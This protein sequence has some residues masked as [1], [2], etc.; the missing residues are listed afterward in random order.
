MDGWWKTRGR[1]LLLCSVN[2][3]KGGKAGRKSEPLPG[4]MFSRIMDTWA[5]LSGRVCSCQKPMTWPNSCTTMPN[6]S[7]FFPMEMA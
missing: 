6:L 7:Q 1:T 4:W 3:W 5:S 2:R